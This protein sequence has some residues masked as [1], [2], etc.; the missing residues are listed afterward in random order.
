MNIRERYNIEENSNCF[1]FQ[2]QKPLQKL[3]QWFL[4]G[5]FVAAMILLLFREMLDE[6]LFFA[7]YI[8]LAYGVFHSLYD[9]M[10]R[11]KIRYTFDLRDNSVYRMSPVSAKKKIMK[12]EETVIFVSS[13]MGSWHY[14]LGAKKSHFI[15][16]Y[17]LSE[18]FS[19][20][21][22]SEQKQ[23]EYEKQVLMKINKLT[24]SV[25]DSKK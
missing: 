9:I 13:E 21:K 1:S 2:P 12:L 7:L 17:A 24:D 14:S 22:K 3:S 11:A 20:G 25:Q 16:S 19:S 5:I 6:T 18:N 23:E 15:K 8:L 10:I 4:A